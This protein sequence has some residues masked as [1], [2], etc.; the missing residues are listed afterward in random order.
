MHVNDPKN[1]DSNTEDQQADSSSTAIPE[2]Y[3]VVRATR[4]Q[5]RTQDAGGLWQI[6]GGAER[7]P[8][9]APDTQ[10]RLQAL[11]AIINRVREEAFADGYAQGYVGK[12]I[13][14]TKSSVDKH[15]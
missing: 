3:V 15:S 13:V 14:D 5:G 11:T 4:P 9:G 1:L 7:I 2:Y 12:E 8:F 10:E 6:V